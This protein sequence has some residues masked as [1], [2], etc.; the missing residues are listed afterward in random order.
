MSKNKLVKSEVGLKY[1]SSG[2]DEFQPGSGR[3]VLKNLLEITSVHEINKIE[4][5]GYIAAE[6][7]VMS[8]FTKD[9][10]LIVNDIHQINK[11]FLGHIY[12]WAGTLRSVNITKNDFT[13]A[14]AFALPSLLDEFE[15]EVLAVH[16]PCHEDS[17]EVVAGHIALVQCELLLMHPYREGNGR[18]ARLVASLMAY[19]AGLPG[20]DFSFIKSRG[21]EFD[22]YVSAIQQGVRKDYAPMTGIVLRALRGALGRAGVISAV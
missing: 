9:Q 3:R 19:Q 1:H 11:W 18:T 17:L 20:I 14:T 15:A 4:F 10:C 12:A 8:A 22:G 7:K 13:F 5:A 16:T 21:K 6:R 2:V